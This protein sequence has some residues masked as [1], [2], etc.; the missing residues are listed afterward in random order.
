MMP[1]A[2]RFER[3][4][5][6]ANATMGGFCLCCLQPNPLSPGIR[7][8]ALVEAGDDFNTSFQDLV[9]ECI[10]KSQQTSGMN[11]RFNEGVLKWILG[12]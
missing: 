8:T 5:G 1:E 4:S 3:I 11:V 12:D 7:I 6:D 9:I 10:G 2:F